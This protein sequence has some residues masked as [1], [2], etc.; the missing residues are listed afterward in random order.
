[1]SAHDLPLTHCADR[2]ERRG[3]ARI[4]IDEV[5]GYPCVE[6]LPDE[7]LVTCE[8]IKEMLADFP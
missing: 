8:Q 1:M 3:S 7:P 6:R 5:T 2:G 4:V